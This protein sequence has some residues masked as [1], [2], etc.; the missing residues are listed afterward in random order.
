MLCDK[1]FFMKK[2]ENFSLFYDKTIII[3]SWVCFFFLL[4]TNI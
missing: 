1:Y 3:L 4:I 2:K